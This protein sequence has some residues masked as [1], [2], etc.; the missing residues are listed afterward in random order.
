[1][2]N[3]SV[4]V[5]T[6]H[7]TFTGDGNINI[8]KIKDQG[9]ENFHILFDNQT[10]LSR[11]EVSKKYDNAFV[12]F[13]SDK[14]FKDNG[15]DKPISKYH[16]WG[17][18]QNPKY[19]YAHYRMLAHYIHNPSFDYY[20][21]FDDDVT[22]NGDLNQCISNFNELDSDF[23]GIQVFKKEDYADFPNVSVI[24]DRMK[25]SRGHWLGHCPGPGDNFKNINKH[26]GSFFPIVRFSNKGLSH[27]LELHNQGFYGYSEGFVPTSLA[28]DGFTVVSMLN[29]FNKF[30]VDNADCDLIHKGDKFTWEW[31]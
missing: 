4:A 27:L 18:H 11:K 3:T 20:W 8:L 22:F 9:F 31:L 7:R 1:M 10:D 14:T 23:I 17:S 15:F 21:Y 16:F 19:F 28:S 24:N 30:L 2:K 5:C 29:E 13:F 6:Y 25:G 12:S 26:M